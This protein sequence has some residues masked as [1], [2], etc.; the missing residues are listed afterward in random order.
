MF[1]LIAIQLM[2]N[3]A[4]HVVPVFLHVHQY[5]ALLCTLLL[6]IKL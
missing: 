3:T 4:E 1:G 5:Q 2:R 6:Q